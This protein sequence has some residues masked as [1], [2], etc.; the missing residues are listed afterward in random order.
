M[1]QCN[2]SG[3]YRV[4]SFCIFSNIFLCYTAVLCVSTFY[5]IYRSRENCKIRL[6]RSVRYLT[7][8]SLIRCSEPYSDVSRGFLRRNLQV[9]SSIGARLSFALS[10]LPE[11]CR[12]LWCRTTGLQCIQRHFGKLCVGRSLTCP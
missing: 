5:K 10:H 7:V 12:N 6:D 3:C 4:N 1:L 11:K 2:D 9:S 8:K